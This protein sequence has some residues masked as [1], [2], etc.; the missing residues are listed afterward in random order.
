MSSSGYTA[1]LC[2]LY[3]ILLYEDTR[4]AAST[5]S[6]RQPGL[7]APKPHRY[8]QDLLNDLPIKYLLGKAETLQVGLTLF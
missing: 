1:Q 8:S 6:Q 5:N 7:T 4:L 2:V 3:Y